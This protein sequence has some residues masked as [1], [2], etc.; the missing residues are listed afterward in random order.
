[1]DAWNLIVVIAAI[2]S[3]F[4]VYFIIERTIRYVLTLVRKEP[5]ISYQPSGGSFVT[6]SDAL[7]EFEYETILNRNANDET[8]T[9]S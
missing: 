9:R 1:M 8:V 6:D 3:V 5:I 2:L 7:S 4:I